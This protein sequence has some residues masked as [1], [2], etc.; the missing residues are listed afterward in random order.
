MSAANDSSATD[1]SRR[2]FVLKALGVIGGVI[3]AGL[4]IPVAGFATAPG[5]R[6]KTPAKFIE[7]SVVPTLRSSEWTPVGLITDFVVG[8]P[9]YIE[10]ERPVTDGWIAETVPIGAHVVRQ[11]DTDVVVFDPHCTHLGCPLAWSSGAGNFV[12]PCHGG[13]FSAAGEVV[14]GPPPHAMIRYETKVENGEIFIGAL[15]EGA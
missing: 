10:V 5:W 12:C 11:S 14:S 9:N 6:A 13:V 2:R 3:A 4:A 15:Q 7:T 8:E 1:I